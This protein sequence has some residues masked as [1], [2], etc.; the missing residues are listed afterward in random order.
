M[1]G[2]KR[3]N[4]WNRDP[5]IVTHD[6]DGGI[7]VRDPQSN[8]V[9]S[10]ISSHPAANGPRTVIVEAYH[11]ESGVYEVFT[12]DSRVRNRPVLTFYAVEQSKMIEAQKAAI[13]VTE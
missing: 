3:R 11:Y 6:D 9:L 1:S 2:R 12:D 5:L 7:T 8:I 10:V 13:G 4:P